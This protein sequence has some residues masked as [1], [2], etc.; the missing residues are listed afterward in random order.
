VCQ[1]AVPKTQPRITVRPFEH[2]CQPLI[3]AP[4]KKRLTVIVRRGALRRFN[5]LKKQT[6]DLPVEVSWDRRERDASTRRANDRRQKPPFTWD[7]S[8][9][10]LAVKPPKRRKHR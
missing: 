1:R 3:V 8:D 6:V 5:K 7:V 10:V 2:P 9:F 4:S